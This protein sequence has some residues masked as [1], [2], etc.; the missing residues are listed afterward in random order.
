[1]HKK[2]K[3]IFSLITLC[4]SLAVLCFG[5]YSAVQVSYSIS[6]SI[7]YEVSGAYANI[8]TKVYG[9]DEFLASDDI[10]TNEM[11]G[12]MMD[13]TINTPIPDLDNKALSDLSFEELEST[14][15]GFIDTNQDYQYNTLTNEGDSSASDININYNNY[16]TYF[17]VIKVQNLADNY[18]SAEISTEFVND[19]INSLWCCTS[20]VLNIQKDTNNGEGK[21]LAIIYT[22][23]DPT[24]SVS[25]IGTAF[26]HLLKIEGSSEMQQITGEVDYNLGENVQ[27]S[28]TASLYDLSTL[29]SEN[30]DD[31]QTNILPQLEQSISLYMSMF[32]Q[33]PP[34]QLFEQ[35]NFTASPIYTSQYDSTTQDSSLALAKNINVDFSEGY[36]Y[37]LFLT[38][39]N[40]NP[41]TFLNAKF[42]QSS[43]DELL[44]SVYASSDLDVVVGE[45]PKN[46]IMMFVLKEQI[47]G[48]GLIDFDNTLIIEN[49]DVTPYKQEQISFEDNSL[50]FSETYFD[51][52]GKFDTSINR[53]NYTL[54]TAV[55]VVGPT[56]ENKDEI[57]LTNLLP[58]IQ[59]IE[60]DGSDFEN[61]FATDWFIIGQI[62]G[63]AALY[64]KQPI[65]IAPIN[66]NEIRF[67]SETDISNSQYTYILF[68]LALLGDDTLAP[69]VLAMLQYYDSYNINFPYGYLEQY[70]LTE[71]PEHYSQEEKDFII[72]YST[73]SSDQRNELQNYY[74]QILDQQQGT[75]FDIKDLLPE[76]ATYSEEHPL[77]IK[78]F[79]I[80]PGTTYKL[81][82][83][84]TDETYSNQVQIKG[85]FNVGILTIPAD[86]DFYI[87]GIES[88]SNQ[89]V[90]YDVEQ[91]NTSYAVQDGVLFTK[92]MSTLVAYPS[93]KVQASYSIPS[94]VTSVNPYAFKTSN[95]LGQ[96]IVN[97]DKMKDIHGFKGSPSSIILQSTE[98]IS[99][100]NIADWETNALP[101]IQIEY[102]D[103]SSGLGYTYRGNGYYVTSYTPTDK[104]MVLIPE[105]Y[106]VK[107]GE[108]LNV[109][110]IGANAFSGA[111]NLENIGLPE[112]IQVIENNAFDG[113]VNVKFVD[114]GNAEITSYGANVFGDR[115]DVIIYTQNETTKNVIKTATPN[116]TSTKM[117]ISI[118]TELGTEE[119]ST[120]GASHKGTFSLTFKIDDKT[121]TINTYYDCLLSDLYNG[122]MIIQSS[123]TGNINTS[124]NVAI[125]AATYDTTDFV[126]HIQEQVAIAKI[127]DD[128]TLTK[129]AGTA[130]DVTYFNHPGGSANV[131]Y[132]GV[133][134]V[135]EELALVVKLAVMTYVQCFTEG[136]LITLADGSTKPIEEIGYDDLLLVYD[137]DRGEFGYS[138]P[139]WITSGTYSNYYLMK[140]DDGSEVEIVLSHRL[141]D[142]DGLTYETSIDATYSQIGDRFFR[143]VLDEDGKPIITTPTC[144]SIERIDEKCTYYNLVTSQSF[145]FFA[146][147]LLGA[148]GAA[149]IYTFE[150]TEDGRYIHNPEQL[151]ATKY[152]G[153][154]F[155]YE[156]FDSE[157]IPY[158]FYL[159]YRLAET[160]NMVT[161][162]SQI[163][164]YN[165]YPPEVVYQ[166]AIE[167]AEAYFEHGY[168]E[169]MYEWPET[170]QVTTSDGLT[171][172]VNPRDTFTLPTPQQT[173]GFIGWYNTLDGKIYQVGEEATIYMNTHFI[174]RY[175]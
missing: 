86:F 57:S 24:V 2:T 84:M 51:I 90:S 10:S 144:I 100:F 9:L 35:M 122:Y 23:K 102:L 53:D 85:N 165:Q 56:V 145:N 134:E 13:S 37:V 99:R 172:R 14:G 21:N 132:D 59:Q 161:I 78:N 97:Y 135:G 71:V 80:V 3:L 152:E 4:F 166:M 8:T 20:K 127:E 82:D 160:K 108:I 169:N 73:M 60:E 103:V 95:N 133:T 38:I 115:T 54:P 155:T 119:G 175:A 106:Q 110:G 164:P 26:S 25:S 81:S 136:T 147:G 124:V 34:E 72:K 156:D 15:L 171:T 167:V 6:G 7:S 162:L 31:F 93:G 173:E 77:I 12:M 114:F 157:I 120:S 83:Y 42:D 142:V 48:L 139:I 65:T 163:P 49:L 140:F 28:V 33:Y 1:M 27:A 138:Y 75:D 55:D 63:Y 16:Y 29:N 92:D 153:N 40:K 154:T 30:F 111:T 117:N 123:S 116:S 131:T 104:T 101:N 46:A 125:S 66:V 107:G 74:G 5:V 130:D 18:I 69:I 128:G 70:G 129:I 17:I 158:E 126:D 118:E 22:L 67:T 41:D 105:T 150:K 98:Y 141:F 113:A 87:T 94:S 96:I 36:F 32:S 143:Q 61:L 146:N 11:L 64:E 19:D 79:R 137:F 149:N 52:T 174:A 148:T 151:Q 50:T 91:G 121:F 47:S 45:E 43:S 168:F 159:A 44:Y 112:T 89:L 68:L 109:V 39:E 62:Y 170:F 88:S 76:G 58:I